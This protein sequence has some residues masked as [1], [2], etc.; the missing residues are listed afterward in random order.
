MSIKLTIHN[1]LF[2]FNFLLINKNMTHVVCNIYIARY[3]SMR[4]LCYKKFKNLR[5]PL[6]ILKS[7][8]DFRKNFLISKEA[9]TAWAYKSNSHYQW[10]EHGTIFVASS[11]LVPRNDNYTGS[12]AARVTKDVHLELILWPIDPTPIDMCY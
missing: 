10:Q 12:S 9:F 5:W 8:S 6:L 4:I 7:G 3:F 2:F 11:D 1:H